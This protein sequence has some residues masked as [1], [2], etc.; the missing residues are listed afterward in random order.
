M[1]SCCGGPW[2]PSWHLDLTPL[3]LSPAADRLWRVPDAAERLV[4]I[5]LGVP[6]CHPATFLPGCP[7]ECKCFPYPAVFLVQHLKNFC[8][9]L[10]RRWMR[11]RWVGDLSRTYLPWLARGQ[12]LGSPALPLCLGLELEWVKLGLQPVVSFLTAPTPEGALG[13]Q[14]LGVL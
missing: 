5:P 6:A 14:T 3:S 13:S 12:D 4:A 1:K 10:H 8:S 11:L 7:A 9:E 2:S